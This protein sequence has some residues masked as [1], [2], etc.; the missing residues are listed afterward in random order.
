MLNADIVV[1][2][3]D[4]IDRQQV[5]KYIYT[6]AHKHAERESETEE[7]MK[8]ICHTTA[9]AIRENWS[10]PNRTEL[11]HVK[12]K[13]TKVKRQPKRGTERIERTPWH[14]HNRNR[15]QSDNVQVQCWYYPVVN[16][17]N[18]VFVPFNVFS[19]K[20]IFDFHCWCRLQSDW[21][22]FRNSHHI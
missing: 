4:S 10:E 3:A 21:I 9:K 6:L 13:A 7:R 11:N 19:T 16:G 14:A 22:G 18:Y 2:A 17:V 5:E 12:P 1:H 20:L 15:N 8:K